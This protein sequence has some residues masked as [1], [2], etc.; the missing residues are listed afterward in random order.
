[1][2]IPLHDLDARLDEVPDGEVWVHCASGYRAAIAASLLDRAGVTVVAI[3]DEWAA[4]SKQ[5]ALR[6]SAPR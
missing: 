6:V 3:D 1:V 2:H 5:E 4:A